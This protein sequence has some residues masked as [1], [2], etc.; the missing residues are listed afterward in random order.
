MS[1]DI[2]EF[3]EDRSNFS[4]KLPA[5]GGAMEPAGDTRAQSVQNFEFPTRSDAYSTFREFS[6]I[7]RA[8]K[9]RSPSGKI[10]II[11]I[12]IIKAASSDERA[13]APCGRRGTRCRALHESRTPHVTVWGYFLRVARVAVNDLLRTC[14]VSFKGTSMRVGGSTQ[15]YAIASRWRYHH[16]SITAR[17]C[18]QAWDSYKTCQ[19]WGNLRSDN[20]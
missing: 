14:G 2:L 10:I 16:N 8:S 17:I 20:A 7:L 6:C 19:I 11:I 4:W 18:L 9:M 5:L 15:P 1:N 3:R 13:L 12:I